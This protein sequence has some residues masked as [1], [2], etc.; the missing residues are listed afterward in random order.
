MHR[1]EARENKQAGPEKHF[2]PEFDEVYN[3]RDFV[4]IFM[5]SDSVTNVTSLNR[6]NH[7]RVLLFI[8]NG[9]GV[10]SYAIGKSSDYEKAYE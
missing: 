4:L 3:P 7:R 1:A 10:I 2:Y 5:D 8:G 6:I 9:Q